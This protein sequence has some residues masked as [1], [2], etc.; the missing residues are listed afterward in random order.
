MPRVLAEAVRE[1]GG[2]TPRKEVIG[3]A[4]LWLGDCR[5]VLPMLGTV[6]SVVTDPPYGIGF[7][8]D[9]HDDTPEGYGIWIWSI[10]EAAESLCLSGS[11]V[12]VWQAQKNIRQLHSWFPRD[13]RLFI[14]ARNFTQMNRDGMPHSYEPVVVWWT[15]GEK[16][17]S[18]QGEGIGVLRDFHVAD[19]AGGLLR[20]K[21]SGA[22]SHPCPRQEDAMEFVIGN[23]VRPSGVV[24]DP[25]MGSGTTGVACARL[26]RRF[27]GIEIHEPYFNI[28][29][30]RIEQAYRQA[31]LFVSRPTP[32]PVVTADLFAARGDGG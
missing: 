28:A 21:I 8:Y 13:W 26:G 19:A 3:D 32:K 14:S 27:I 29:V 17:H 1:A 15:E 5:D 7:K 20:N 6:D 2:M 16:W 30:R 12:F 24:L 18:P 4:E 23:W 25:F 11:P 31:D 22:S 10:I 9:S